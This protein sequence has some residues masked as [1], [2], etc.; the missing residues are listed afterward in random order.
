MAEILRKEPEARAVLI[1][2]T[3][4][5]VCKRNPTP[6]S[7]YLYLFFISDIGHAT[8]PLRAWRVADSPTYPIGFPLATAFAAGSIAT[9]SALYFWVRRFVSPVP[10]RLFPLMTRAADIQNSRCTVLP[11]KLNSW[12]M[13]LSRLR[14]SRKRRETT[15]LISHPKRFE[16]AGNRQIV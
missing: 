8:I 4:T 2:L 13:Q 1:G 7:Q 12:P 10:F 16:V 9:I 11:E 6:L 15:T 14:A 3:V 5:L